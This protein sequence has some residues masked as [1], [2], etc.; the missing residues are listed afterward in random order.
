MALDIV[1]EGL[2][3]GAGT[4]QFNN[5]N[6]TAGVGGVTLAFP[7]GMF[8]WNSEGYLRGGT[9]TNTGALQ[10]TG[11]IAH[12]DGSAV[13]INAGTITQTGGRL[14]FNGSNPTLHNLAGGLYEVKFAGPAPFVGNFSGGEVFRND[15]TLRRDGTGNADMNGITFQNSSSGKIEAVNGSLQL[16]VGGTMQGATFNVSAGAAVNLAG[17]T[18]TWT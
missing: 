14:D 15:G 3:S 11:N 7:A 4:V 2:G 12:I 1:E 17:I 5:A 13:L 16:N 8:D 10:I 18:Q 9:F 6:L